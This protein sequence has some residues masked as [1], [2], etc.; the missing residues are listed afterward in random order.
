MYI[1]LVVLLVILN[2][3]VLKNE[4]IENGDKKFIYI[5]FAICGLVMGLRNYT[6]GRD[7][8]SYANIYY[9]V[10]NMDMSYILSDKYDSK[11]EFGY[12]F[13]MKLCSLIKYDYF[14][15]QFVVSML[16]CLGMAKF[17]ADNTEDKFLAACI[18]LGIGLYLSAFSAQ[19]QFLAIMFV[20]NSWTLLKKHKK[21]KAFLLILI[22]FSIHRSSM[23]FF[24]AFALFFFR[25]NRFLL[26]LVPVMIVFIALNISS[27]VTL[28][29]TYLTQYEKY[30]SNTA[31]ILSARGSMIMW[32]IIGILSIYMIYGKYGVAGTK[33]LEAILCLL[34]VSLYYVGT[35]FNLVERIGDYFMPFAMTMLSST[36]AMLFSKDVKKIYRTGVIFCFIAFFIVMVRN[37]PE[38]AY[39]MFFL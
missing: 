14:F 17:V 38:L 8:V 13:M 31:D 23:V 28:F 19:R 12:V 10:T 30:V 32:L 9:N 22:A 2:F 20:A 39:S 21:M 11:M 24:G 18:F 5:F 29:S 16:F 15:F 1:G 26:K 36:D 25:K 35:H 4:K 3:A 6:V 37:T 7:T 27:I 34:Y 33:R